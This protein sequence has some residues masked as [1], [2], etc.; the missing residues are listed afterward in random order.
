[1][2]HLLFI[3]NARIHTLDPLRPTAQALAVQGARILTAGTEA[4]VRAQLTAAGDAPV[5]TI[6]ARGAALI[7]GFIDTH[8]HLGITGLGMLAIDLDGVSTIPLVLA[9]IAETATT[10]PKD[11]LL[12]A[13]N[14]QP[15]LNPENRIPTPAELDQAGAG[16]PVY[17]MDRTGHECA[18]NAAA[19]HLAGLVP[20]EPGVATNADGSFQGLVSGKA[21]T[22]AFTRLW[23]HFAGDMGIDRPLELAVQAALRAGITSLHALDD[24]ETVQHLVAKSSQLP[25][26]VIPY[27]QTQDVAAVKALGL[28]Q[29]GGCGAVMVDGDFGPRTAALLEPYTDLPESSGKLYYSDADL[30]QYVGAA[31]DAGLQ[32]A[33]HCVGSAAIEQLLN[34]FERVLQRSPRPDH[35]HRIEHFELPAPGQ[36]ER[37]KRLGICLALQPAFNH[38]W[39]HDADYPDRIGPERSLQVDPLASLVKLGIPLALGS[40]SPVTPLRPLLWLYSAANHS[41]PAERVSIET[42]LGL[43]THAGAYLA[44][45]ERDKGRIIPGMLADFVFLS[46]SPLDVPLERI[47]EIQV[48]KTVIGGQ[49]VFDAQGELA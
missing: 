37:A 33:L 19:L 38:Y 45:E 32:I 29:I 35:R 40:D 3:H 23:E 10:T 21:N 30:E 39:P 42:A 13:L 24:L 44:F 22:R 34:T 14:F 15:E 8:A 31:H 41:N 1:M 6:D 28:N 18:L 47:R 12:V 4:E 9:R 20:G 48:L 26:R 46:E 11:A 5:E 7:P 49:V 27:T 2:T 36:A 43:A 17:V 25:L 16:R